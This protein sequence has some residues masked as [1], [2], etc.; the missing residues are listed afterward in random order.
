MAPKP[1]IIKAFVKSEYFLFSLILSRQ[2]KAV[3]ILCYTQK[4][5]KSKQNFIS[6]LCVCCY[7]QDVFICVYTES[8]QVIGLQQES[9]K[10]SDGILFLRSILFYSESMVGHFYCKKL[11]TTRNMS[12]E[13]VYSC[14]HHINKIL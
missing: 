2:K 12:I 8:K 1:W 10:Y 14:V 9:V 11:E 3:G 4:N 13:L 5:L 7:Q 6:R